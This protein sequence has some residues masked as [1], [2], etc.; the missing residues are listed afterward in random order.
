M[1]TLAEVRRESGDVSI[2][3][4]RAHVRDSSQDRVR[5]EWWSGTVF[6]QRGFGLMSARDASVSSSG[7]I[8][9]GRK[10]VSGVAVI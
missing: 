8:V 3:V 4:R 5:D 6:T 10:L 7:K 2:I 1:T 9:S